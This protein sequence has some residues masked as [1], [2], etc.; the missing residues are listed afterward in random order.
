MKGKKTFRT[1]FMIAVAAAMAVLLLLEGSMP[2]AQKPSGRRSQRQRWKA[3]K[4]RHGQ[5]KE[6]NRGRSMFMSVE[7]IC[8]KEGTIRFPINTTKMWELPK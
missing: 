8:W 1:A 6:S 7:F 5:G 3:S 4:T 2:F